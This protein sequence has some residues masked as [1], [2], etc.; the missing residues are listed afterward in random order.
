MLR[1]RD[2]AVNK[3]N[4]NSALTEF[5]FLGGKRGDKHFKE[6]K[7]RVYQVVVADWKGVKQL[8]KG[9]VEAQG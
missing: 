4:K 1:A 8:R 5:T 2:S 9:G 6:V 3:S 7:D